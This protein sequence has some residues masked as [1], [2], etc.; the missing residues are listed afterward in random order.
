MNADARQVLAEIYRQTKADILADTPITTYYAEQA[1]S[2][3]ERE[4]KKE[5]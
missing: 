5:A 4:S 3:N 2:T 1:Q